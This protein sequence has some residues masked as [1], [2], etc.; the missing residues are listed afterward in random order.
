MGNQQEK[1]LL[2]RWPCEEQASHRAHVVRTLMG[3]MLVP[4]LAPGAFFNRLP[5]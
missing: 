2:K 5:R 1:K 4:L 3:V